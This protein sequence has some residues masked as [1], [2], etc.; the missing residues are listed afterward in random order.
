MKRYLAFLIVF[1]PL[2]L[3]AKASGGRAEVCGLQ[4]RV[5]NLTVKTPDVK[6]YLLKRVKDMCDN[7]DYDIGYQ[8]ETARMLENFRRTLRSYSIREI[9]EEQVN[10][11]I[12]HIRQV[13][14]G[15]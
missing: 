5:E 15:L 9:P 14:R 8:G 11:L 4:I 13:E 3:P 7:F 10:G 2:L 12:G 1:I 6:K